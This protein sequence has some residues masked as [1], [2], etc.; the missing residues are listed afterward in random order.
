MYNKDFLYDNSTMEIKIFYCK[1]NKE[2][3]PESHDL[4]E[5]A[6]KEYT[7]ED[8]ADFTVCTDTKHGKPYVKE[9][10]DV[11]FSITHG[12]GYWACAVGG[13][14]V[15]LDIQEIRERKTDKIAERFFHPSEIAYL[16]EHGGPE[17]FFRI[18]AKKESYVKYT[19]KGLTEGL[20]Y[21]SVVDGVPAVQTEIPFA[22][23]CFLVLTAGNDQ[24]FNLEEML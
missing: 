1:W 20:D 10:P 17:E 18:W 23:D 24:E 4:L 14:E 7:G 15:G 19:G 6:L 12:G 9:L 5:R 11:H 22:K 3:G 8:P 2:S 13:C 16:A 21:F